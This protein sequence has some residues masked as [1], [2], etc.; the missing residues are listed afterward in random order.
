[1]GCLHSSNVIDEIDEEVQKELNGA[2]NKSQGVKKLL[3]LGA[4]GS[5]KST[6]FKQLRNIMGGGFDERSRMTFRSQIYEQII[7]AMKVM[8]IK[9]QEF[10]DD[11]ISNSQDSTIYKIKEETASSADNLLAT[12]NCQEMN[13]NV[14]GYLKTLWNDP[15][16]KNTFEIRNRICVPDSTAYFLDNID[17][18]TANNYV[19]NENDLFLVRYATTGMTEKDFVIDGVTVKFC[20]VGGQRCER[21][22]WI[23]FFD[24]VTAIIF[25]ASLS[26]YDEVLFEDENIN[27]MRESLEIFKEQVNSHLFKNISFILFLNKKDIF[28]NKIKKVPITVCFPEYDGLQAY[29]PSLEYIREQFENSSENRSSREFYTHATCATDSNNIRHV[30]NDVQDVI[31]KD[32]LARTGL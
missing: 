20:D 27:N 7:D 5:G 24:N 4:G 25:V 9:A 15:A 31:I 11:Q 10:A 30:F 14:V 16:I 32:G 3:L 2:Q 29:Q 19:P 22:K 6:L 26:C 23:H 8:I 13:A 1:M 28:Q 12:R 18:I 21:R 17:R